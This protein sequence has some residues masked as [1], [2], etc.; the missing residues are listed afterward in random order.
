MLTEGCD[1]VD[2]LEVMVDLYYMLVEYIKVKV[3]SKQYE[4]LEEQLEVAIHHIVQQLTEV[5]EQY[6]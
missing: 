1:E 5:I 4:V 3:L 2:E 6:E